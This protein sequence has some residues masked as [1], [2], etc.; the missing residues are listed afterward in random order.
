MSSFWSGW[1]IFFATLNIVLVGIVH[2]PY[3]DWL[4]CC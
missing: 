3:S 1:V 4:E 2:E